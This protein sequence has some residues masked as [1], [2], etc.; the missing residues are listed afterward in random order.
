M[1][2]VAAL[3]APAAQLDVGTLVGAD[4]HARV[5]QVRHRQQQRLQ[6]AL[7]LLQARGRAFELGLV[8]GDLGHHGLGLGVLA[9]ALE[10]ADLL[11]EAVAPGLQLLGAHLQRLAL[12]LK[13]LEGFHVQEGLRVL[14]GLQAGDD[15]VEI[16]AQEG[17]V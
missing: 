11:R 4:R 1:G 7:D 10:H 9:L 15:G 13:R 8:L 14:A 6:L 12:V 2:A 5:R 16:F 17:D 3:R